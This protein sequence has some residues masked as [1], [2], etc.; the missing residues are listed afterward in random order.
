MSNEAT[1][2]SRAEVL[3]AEFA[4]ALQLGENPSI[5][6]YVAQNQDCGPELR[7]ML[8]SIL[9]ME[10]LKDQNEPVPPSPIHDGS[11]EIRRLGDL[12]I[13]REIGRGGMGIVYEAVQESLGRT[14]TS[15]YA[16]RRRSNPE[17]SATKHHLMVGFRASAST[18]TCFARAASRAGTG[19]RSGSKR[20]TRRE[21]DGFRLR[22]SKCE[23]A[24]PGID[25]SAPATEGSPLEP[26]N[27]RARRQGRR[28]ARPRHGAFGC[29]ACVAY[30][31]HHALRHAVVH[32]SSRWA[33]TPCSFS[34]SAPAIFLHTAKARRNGSGCA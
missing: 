7:E 24:E 31:Q 34:G 18:S 9:A 15:T 8:L 10:Q 14:P 16:R 12:R 6:D 20:T 17:S 26:S 21:F 3:A 5:D 11:V 2:Y 4:E 19:H 32:A 33:P 1:E 13:V 30:E 28:A 29:S 25:M 27:E 22:I 23:R